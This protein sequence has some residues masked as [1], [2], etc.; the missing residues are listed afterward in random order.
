MQKQWQCIS[1]EEGPDLKLFKA[2]FDFMQ[3][4]RN[5]K[6]EKMLI[7]EGADSVNVV[8]LSPNDT[9]YFVQQYRFGTRKHT[10]ELP[11]GLVDPNE[12]H[13]I[14]AARELEEETGGKA[15]QW[16][17]L[18][19]IASNPVFMDSYIHHWLAEGVV[20]SGTQSLDEGED[21]SVVE[22]PLD[23]VKHRLLQGSFSHPHTVTALLRFFIHQSIPLI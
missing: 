8:A 19:S 10:L 18:G 6:T 22:L 3:N 12:A 4:P 11:G 23:E 13:H 7:L 1:Q 21:V 9:I 17:F 2:R 20:L 14:A 16:H 15:R 5:G